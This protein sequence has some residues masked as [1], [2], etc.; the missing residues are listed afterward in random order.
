MRLVCSLINT[1]LP[2]NLIKNLDLTE[3]VFEEEGT[4]FF[5]IIIQLISLKHSTQRLD[6]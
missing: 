2:H 6:I 1:T 5:L 3:R 4:V